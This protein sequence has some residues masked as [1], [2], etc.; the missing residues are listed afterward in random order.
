MGNDTE[1]EKS[2]NLNDEPSTSD[3]NK[4]KLTYIEEPIDDDEVPYIPKTKP[5]KGISYSVIITPLYNRY[6][7][8]I[9]YYIYIIR[10][11]FFYYIIYYLIK[12][13]III[14]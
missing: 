5:L 9:I 6:I 10:I 4:P 7:I 14:L 8:T 3:I 12:Y 1:N 13:I 2:N 11:F